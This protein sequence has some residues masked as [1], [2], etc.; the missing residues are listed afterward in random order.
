MADWRIA[1]EHLTACEKEYGVIEC[2]GYLILN[3]VIRPLRDRLNKG[4]RTDELF[5]EIMETQL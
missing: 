3:Y 5:S 1:E 4:E 2:A